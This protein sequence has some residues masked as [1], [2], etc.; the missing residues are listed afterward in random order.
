MDPRWTEIAIEVMVEHADQSRPSQT[1]VIDRTNARVIARFGEGVVAL[2]SRAT[3][4][5][6]LGE[7]ENRYRPS[8]ECQAES[9]HRRPPKRCLRKTA[10]DPPG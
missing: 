3:A 4:F 6:V 2:P 10:P 8:L 9:R 1:M 7:L 5:R